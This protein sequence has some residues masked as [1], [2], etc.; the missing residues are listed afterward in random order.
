MLQVELPVAALQQTRKAQIISRCCSCLACADVRWHDRRGTSQ[1]RCATLIFTG[2]RRLADVRG[3]PLRR[4]EALH[5]L[6][7]SLIWTR[8]RVY[9]S[10]VLL[11]QALSL[12][13]W[14]HPHCS[15][16]S[17]WHGSR[18][19]QRYGLAV[20]SFAPHGGCGLFGVRCPRAHFV[21]QL[22]VPMAVCHNW[23]Y[24]ARST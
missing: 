12:L 7:R 9:R 4:S 17:W 1:Q 14:D 5:G 22:R 8:E 24:Y 11:S 15:P 3:H 21:L 18:A 20:L 13:W 10:R 2:I 6:S 19:G 16:S 23:R